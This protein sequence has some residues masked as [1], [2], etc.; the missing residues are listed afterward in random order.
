MYRMH[1][2][3]DDV[4]AGITGCGDLNIEVYGRHPNG[5]RN[6]DDFAEI[7]IPA[8]ALEPLFQLLRR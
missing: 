5:Q 1:H 2:L 6:E 4:R 8:D 7:N 3:T